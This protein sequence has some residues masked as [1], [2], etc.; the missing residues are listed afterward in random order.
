MKSTEAGIRFPAI[1]FTPD[2]GMWGF[3]DLDGLTEC[4]PMTLRKNMQSGM[5]VIDSDGRRW[6]VRSIR[7]IGRNKPLLPWLL[8]RLLSGPGWRIEQELEEMPPVTLEDIRT[9]A[10]EFFEA[11][12]DDLCPD[13]PNSQDYKRLLK[14]VRAAKSVAKLRELL[15][16]DWFVAY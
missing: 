13:G 5:E 10:S 1:G 11:N 9:R 4:G 6:V 12:A 14:Q 8:S 7:R 15:G 3:A 16:L 2:G